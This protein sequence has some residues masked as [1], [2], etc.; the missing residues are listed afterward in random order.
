MKY[1]ITFRVWHWLNAF[2]VLGLVATVILRKTFL[3]WRDNSAL[4]V[5]K[6]DAIGVAITHEQAVM[7]AKA[8][9]AGM[10]EWHIILGYALTF[11]VLYRIYLYF[12]E[13]KEQE[14]FE[15]LSLHKKGVR[16]SYYLLDAVLVFM[17]VSGLLI[18]FHAELGLSKEGAHT[19]KEIHEFLYN[20]IWIFIIVHI[21]GV[22]IADNRDEEG[23]VSSMINGK[24]KKL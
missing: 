17:V 16:I 22:V 13:K 14:K 18:H 8:I 12:F 7:I 21:A 15:S 11:L 4:I 24:E 19:L 5:E 6:L 2:V 9:R 23:L 3:S 10:W 1:S 20:Y